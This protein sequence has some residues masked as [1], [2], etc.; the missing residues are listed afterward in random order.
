M[1]WQKAEGLSLQSVQPPAREPL[2]KA[3]RCAFEIVCDNAAF[4]PASCHAFSDSDCQAS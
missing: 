2:T 4:H 3:A 1:L